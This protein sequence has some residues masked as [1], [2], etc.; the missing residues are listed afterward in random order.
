MCDSNVKI[1]KN[2]KWCKVKWIDK[3]FF[4]Y[5]FATCAAPKAK[6]TDLVT[7]KKSVRWEFCSVQRM[8]SDS[9]DKV[10]CDKDGKF[11]EPK[12]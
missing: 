7:G 3:L 4:G 6:I 10:S 5:Q 2:C 9:G 1:C 8:W 12:E 11:F